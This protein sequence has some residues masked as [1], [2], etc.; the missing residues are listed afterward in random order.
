VWL[1]DRLELLPDRL[2][3]LRLLYLTHRLA[4]RPTIRQLLSSLTMRTFPVSLV[5]LVVLVIVT[6]DVRLSKRCIVLAAATHVRSSVE[7][8][9]DARA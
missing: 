7:T 6:A 5:V 9:A 8:S 4:K 3:P 2:W 1:A